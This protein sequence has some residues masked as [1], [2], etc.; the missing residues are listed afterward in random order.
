MTSILELPTQ[1]YMYMVLNEADRNY[2][3]KHRKGRKYRCDNETH[4]SKNTE[5]GDWQGPGWY[6]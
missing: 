5:Y 3:R 6:R 4:T 2:K 1:C